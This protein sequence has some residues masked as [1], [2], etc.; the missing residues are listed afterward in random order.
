M[1]VIKMIISSSIV[2]DMKKSINQHPYLRNILEKMVADGLTEDEAVD[3][4][5]QV[6]LKKTGIVVV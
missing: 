3:I 2:E 1:V 6:W 5:I 4:M